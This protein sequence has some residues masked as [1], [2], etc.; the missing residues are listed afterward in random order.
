MHRLCPH[1]T[2]SDKPGKCLSC[3]LV[4][5]PHMLCTCPFPIV[6]W[7]CMWHTLSPVLAQLQSSDTYQDSVAF[8]PLT[9][10][11]YGRTTSSQKHTVGTEC[12]SALSG[13]WTLGGEVP[14]G[15]WLVISSRTPMSSTCPCWT[16]S[17]NPRTDPPPPAPRAAP[18]PPLALSLLPQPLKV[19]G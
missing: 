4:S 5:K 14:G 8:S 7:T 11:L 3:E 16:A 18:P 13:S 19:G 6:H 9:L 15:R 12:P 10:V 17:V 1:L 2:P